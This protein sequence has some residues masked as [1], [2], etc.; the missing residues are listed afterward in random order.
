MMTQTFIKPSVFI[1]CENLQSRTFKRYEVFKTRG[2]P[3]MD[4]DYKSWL[5]RSNLPKFAVG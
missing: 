1:N 3:E 4:E 5:L 2:G